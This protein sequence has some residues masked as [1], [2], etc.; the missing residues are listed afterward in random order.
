MTALHRNMGK[1]LADIC[2]KDIL[3]LHIK[4]C[5]GGEIIDAEKF[6]F[7]HLSMYLYLC[8]TDW[9]HRM[10]IMN[11]SESQPREGTNPSFYLGCVD[12]QA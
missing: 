12:G 4:K 6:Y 10:E 7:I 2:I 9:L 5:I 8:T 11:K 1:A 3:L